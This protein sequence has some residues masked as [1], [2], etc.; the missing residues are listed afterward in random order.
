MAGPNISLCIITMSFSSMCPHLTQSDMRSS[1]LME[2][3]FYTTTLHYTTLLLQRLITRYYYL[4]ASFFIV[5]THIIIIQS[6]LSTENVLHH[7]ECGVIERENLP[8][9]R[10]SHV[11]GRSKRRTKL[12]RNPRTILP[13]QLTSWIRYLRTMNSQETQTMNLYI[14]GSA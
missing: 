5:Q 2:H 9:G 1:R 10:R 3:N 11:Q 8:S 7:K 12:E 6:S 13:F 14:S 4:E